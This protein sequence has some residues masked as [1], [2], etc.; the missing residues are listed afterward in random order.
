MGRVPWIAQ[1]A[2]CKHKDPGERQE[3]HSPRDGGIRAAGTVVHCADGRRG[4]P[5]RERSWKRQRHGFVPR[6]PGEMQPH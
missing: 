3:G 6:A 4:L 5:A 1:A 2:Q